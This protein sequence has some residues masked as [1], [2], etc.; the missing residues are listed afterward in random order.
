MTTG[1]TDRAALAAAV[2]DA[3][4]RVPGV[5]VLTGQ[6]GGAEV[7]TLYP[8]G[9]I[10]GVSLGQQ[11]VRI[12]IVVDRLPIGRV[13]AQAQAAALAVLAAAGADRQVDVLVVDLELD[14]LPRPVTP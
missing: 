4:V 11:T 10:L 12:H 14:R 1:L 3:V 6:G 8:G 2:A 5:S 7:A 9:K 13:A